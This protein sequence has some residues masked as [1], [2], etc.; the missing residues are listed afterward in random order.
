MSRNLIIILTSNVAVLV[1][2]LTSATSARA[3]DSFQSGMDAYSKGDHSGAHGH[4]HQAL[5]QNPKDFR[6]YYQLGNIHLAAGDYSGAEKYYRLCVR[7]SPDVATAT[8]CATALDFIGKRGAARHHVSRVHNI[9]RPL[10][11]QSSLPAMPQIGKPEGEPSGEQQSTLEHK[12]AKG[13][14]DSHAEALSSAADAN[15]KLE[16]DR[17][18]AEAEKKAEKIKQAAEQEVRDGHA[19]ANQWW[20][21]S[22]GTIGVMMDEEEEKAIRRQADAKAA[23]VLEEARRKVRALERTSAHVVDSADGLKSQLSKGSHLQTRGTNLYV[24]NYKRPDL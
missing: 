20:R 6:A 4:F 12:E 10:A 22:D 17:I 1:F 24:R 5:A 23:A 7:N 18:M 11:K 15:H 13:L 19:N 2:M 16:K 8:H 9:G 21:F 14:L 3:A